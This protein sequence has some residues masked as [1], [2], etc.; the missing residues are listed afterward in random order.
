MP[1]GRLTLPFSTARTTSSIPIRRAVSCW[2]SSWIRTAYFCDPNTSTWATPA[3]V[4]RRWDRKVSAYSFSSGSG[5]VL[6]RSA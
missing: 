5:R 4:E 6:L 2:G 1:V 3:T